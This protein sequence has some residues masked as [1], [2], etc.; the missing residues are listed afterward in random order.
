MV[1]A[2]P[3]VLII[4]N[5]ETDNVNIIIMKFKSKV[6][7]FTTFHEASFVFVKI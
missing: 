2:L 6:K 5:Y 3:S 4:N 1:T 7:P